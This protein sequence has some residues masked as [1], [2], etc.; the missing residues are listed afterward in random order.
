MISYAAD[1][2]PIRCRGHI[3]FV[4]TAEKEGSTYLGR[5]RIE[6]A[7]AYLPNAASVPA[8]D[9]GAKPRRLLSGRLA[10]DWLTL[11]TSALVV[12]RLANRMSRDNLPLISR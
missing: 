2:S 12:Q 11:C 7:R 3:I 5:A 10:G 1:R 9:Q 6:D 4:L 8:Q